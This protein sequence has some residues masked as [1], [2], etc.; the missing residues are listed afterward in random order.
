MVK[1]RAASQCEAN[2]DSC[3]YILWGGFLA[4]GEW[5]GDVVSSVGC[6]VEEM[7][8]PACSTWAVLLAS[9]LPPHTPDRSFCGDTGSAMLREHPGSS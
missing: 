4:G 1:H 9:L 7:S 2:S 6:G 8:C 3:Y 5:C